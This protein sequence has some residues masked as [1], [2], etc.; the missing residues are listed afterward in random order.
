M[1]AAD[2][3]N[4]FAYVVQVSDGKLLG[5]RPLP[6]FEWLLTAGRNI[7]QL[8]NTVHLGVRSTTILVTDVWTQKTLFRH[9]FSPAARFS[10]LEPD[11]LA[12]FEPSGD[13][14][15]IDVNTGARSSSKSWT[16]R[17]ICNPFRPSN[18]ATSCSYSS[19]ARCRRNSVRSVRPSIT[20]SSMDPSTAF[21]LKT[22]E[23]LWP[24]P[25]LVRSRGLIFAQPD[26]V[27]CLVFVDRQTIRD[28]TNG[29]GFQLRVLCLDKRTG[30]TV[31]RNDSLPDTS[32]S[33]LRIRGENDTHPSVALEMSAGT[34]QL[35]MTERPRPPQPPGNDDLEAPREIAERGLRG[36]GERMGNALA[37]ALERPPNG[38]RPPVCRIKRDRP[39]R[40]RRRPRA[41]TKNRALSKVRART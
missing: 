40:S 32:L 37:G 14:Q 28:A 19:A 12:V 18:P 17:A 16:K 20:R 39:S 4:H 35:T 25:A 27:P 7:A 22:G 11:K 3:G 30:Q 8:A 34:I 33:R 13:F 29:G 36:L 21:S 10:V 38:A 41:T 5:K 15:V 24:G 2:I 6:R 1:F 26:D 9:D 31:Y 23:P